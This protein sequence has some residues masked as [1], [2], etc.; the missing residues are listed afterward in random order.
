MSKIQ[1]LPED[2]IKESDI[3]HMRRAGDRRFFCLSP[4][5]KSERIDRSRSLASGRWV[6]RVARLSEEILDHASITTK[7][8]GAIEFIKDAAGFIMGD[9]NSR[10]FFTKE[11]VIDEDRTKHLVEG[12]RVRF[13]PHTFSNSKIAQGIE[14]L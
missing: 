2:M 8:D 3:L 1:K 14:V 12:R 4:L 10:Y 13:I 9:D 5:F 11:Y 7:I 6:P